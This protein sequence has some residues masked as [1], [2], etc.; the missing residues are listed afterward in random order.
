LKTADRKV[1][2]AFSSCFCRILRLW[3]VVEGLHARDDDDM[4]LRR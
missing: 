3:R 2:E 4:R 1:F